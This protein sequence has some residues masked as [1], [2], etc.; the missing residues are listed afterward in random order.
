MKRVFPLLFLAILTAVGASAQS[1][2][3][4]TEIDEAVEI[5]YG[6]FCYLIGTSTAEV[7]D[8]ATYLQAFE[9]IRK[10]G[11][12]RSDVMAIDPIPLYDIALLC[13]KTWNIKGSLMYMATKS[14]RYA[15][16]QMQAL[17]MIP[18]TADPV[19]T[20]TGHQVLNI[21]TKCIDYGSEK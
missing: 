20:A 17:E 18:L 21:I 7:D 15:F 8:N 14:A 12:F 13:S 16:K 19:S 2:Q 9:T 11:I 10:T 4:I 1:A 3:R 5:S 6:Q